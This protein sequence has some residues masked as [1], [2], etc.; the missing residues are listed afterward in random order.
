[1]G[2]ELHQVAR[3]CGLNA[4]AASS[5]ASSSYCLFLVYFSSSSS[6]FVLPLALTFIASW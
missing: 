6:F 4:A 1:M 3:C 2:K 5:A